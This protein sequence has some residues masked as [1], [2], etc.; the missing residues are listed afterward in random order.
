M[1]LE[2]QIRPLTDKFVSAVVQS[3]ETHLQA[4]TKELLHAAVV[5]AFPEEAAPAAKRK[6]PNVRRVKA[7]RRKTVVSK[8][9]AAARKLQGMYMGGLRGL[10]KPAQTKAKAACAKDGLAAAVKLIAKLK[11]S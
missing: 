7:N 9:V 4:R 5:S 10:S 2:Q 11:K 8:T 6:T 3:I 1:T